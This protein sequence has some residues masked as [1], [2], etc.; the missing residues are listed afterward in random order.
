MI[1]DRAASSLLCEQ[2]PLI[3]ILLELALDL[4]FLNCLLQLLHFTLDLRPPFVFLN[5]KD[6][7]RPE[8]SL[9]SELRFCWKSS[10]SPAAF[11]AVSKV[12]RILFVPSVAG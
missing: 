8:S 10:K 4:N 11:S 3:E 7:P 1:F 2:L 9:I 12:G 6:F 5:L